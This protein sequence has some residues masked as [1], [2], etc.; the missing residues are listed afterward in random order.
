VAHI[1]EYLVKVYKENSE[2]TT[3]NVPELIEMLT[4]YGDEVFEVVQERKQEKITIS[5]VS[6]A[7]IDFS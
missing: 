6:P 7:V 3:P 1:Q 4:V 5:I 2:R